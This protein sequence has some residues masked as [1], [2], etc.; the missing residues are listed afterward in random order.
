MSGFDF[1]VGFEDGFQRQ[2]GGGF[3]GRAGD[4]NDGEF[5]ALEVK[6]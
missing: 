1:E 5:F 6:K 4:T 3:A 2:N